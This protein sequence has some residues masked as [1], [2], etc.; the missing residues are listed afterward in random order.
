M[1]NFASD[2]YG[3]QPR[4]YTENMIPQG[5]PATHSPNYATGSAPMPAPAG[6]VHVPGIGPVD[7]DVAESLGFLPSSAPAVSSEPQ[8]A[9]EF[10][11]EPVEPED[12]EMTDEELESLQDEIESLKDR[13]PSLSPTVDEIAACFGNDFDQAVDR[14]VVGTNEDALGILSEATGLDTATASSLIET[15]VA[16]V[17]PIASEYIGPDCWN[18]IVYA[19]SATPDP[20][21]R[22][23]VSDFVTGKLHP[24]KLARG[25]QL[26]WASLPDADG[27]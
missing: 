25:Y 3:L 4:T 16:D 17:S 26:W 18:A 22:R 12:Y 5:A 27:E 1:T 8:E 2:G 24:S 21:A 13:E 14:L 15:A 6:T 10:P 19:A 11:Q 23:I 9:P 20:Y 7:A